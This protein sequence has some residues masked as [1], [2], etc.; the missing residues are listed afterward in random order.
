MQGKDF[1]EARDL[2]EK[3]KNELVSMAKDAADDT[4]KKLGF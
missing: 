1:Q 3:S 2:L 4:K